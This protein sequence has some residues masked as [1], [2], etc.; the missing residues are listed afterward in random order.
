MV[1]KR[2]FRKNVQKIGRYNDF[3]QETISKCVHISKTFL[4]HLYSIANCK[5]PKFILG[6]LVK[7]CCPFVQL[8]RRG[9]E[10]CNLP[11]QRNS[12]RKNNLFTKLCF[13]NFFGHW[14][15]TLRPIFSKI[16]RRGC[17][18][19]ILR[20]QRNSLRK[21]IYWGTH[22]FSIILGHW[23]KLFWPFFWK[24]F[25]GVLKTAFYVSTGTVWNKIYFLKKVYFLFIIA[26]WDKGF[27]LF[28]RK[29]SA[30]PSKLHSTYPKEHFAENIFFRQNWNFKII[31][32]DWAK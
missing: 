25:R 10:I 24:T 9:C 1:G 8:F 27:W 28:V 32:G 14:A 15:K 3:S 26:H 17:Q 7:N 2:R 6:K 21:T 22:V 5:V 20:V 31:F 18:N 30:V 23:A 12:F 4:F 13:F 19:C 11:V 16:L 29:F